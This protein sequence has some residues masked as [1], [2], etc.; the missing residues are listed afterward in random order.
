MTKARTFNNV[1]VLV[2]KKF[3]KHMPM[4]D[5]FSHVESAVH[6]AKELVNGERLK[7][8]KVIESDMRTLNMQIEEN[9]KSLN[10]LLKNT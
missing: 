9:I 1:E 2:D 10:S 4:D 7:A 3:T 6:Y 5:L 8:M